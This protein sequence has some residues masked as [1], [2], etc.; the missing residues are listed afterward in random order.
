VLATCLQDVLAS[1]NSSSSGQ[2]DAEKGGHPAEVTAWDEL[3]GLVLGHCAG[4]RGTPAMFPAI[5]MP[6]SKV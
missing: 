6:A 4:L 5:S 1:T 2:T 3:N